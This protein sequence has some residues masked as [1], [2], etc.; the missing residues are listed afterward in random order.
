MGTSSGAPTFLLKLVKIYF[1]SVVYFGAKMSN[2]ISNKVKNFIID[3]EKDL[4]SCNA[5]LS[6]LLDSKFQIASLCNSITAYLNSV[7]SGISEVE[8]LE[9]QASILLNSFSELLRFSEK[10]PTE[11]NNSFNILQA[12]RECHTKMLED[13]GKL[14]SEVKDAEDQQNKIMEQLEIGNSSSTKTKKPRRKP[15]QRP[16]SVKSERSSL[17]NVKEEDGE[18]A[19]EDI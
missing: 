19:L 10:Y 15:G 1:C 11:I 3:A 8:N 5:D 13:L 18:I 6:K 2:V 14:L 9:D 4:S 17:P 12:K 7:M 16:E